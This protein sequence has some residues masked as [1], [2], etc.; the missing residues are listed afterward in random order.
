[1]KNKKT[2]P[3]VFCIALS[4][5]I[6]GLQSCEDDTEICG[7]GTTPRLIIKFYDEAT[8]TEISESGVF[9]TTEFSDYAF[10][11]QDSIFLPLS[12]TNEVDTLFYQTSTDATVTDTIVLTFSRKEEYVS[13]GCGFKVNYYN[14]NAT[15]GTTSET[16]Q[17]IEFNPNVVDADNQ[18]NITDE[19]EAHMFIYF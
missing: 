14:I 15:L 19:T 18:I 10:S 3:I 8:N 6:F 17:K 7:E 13:K 4:I 12:L 9:S 2:L 5:I 11:S 16:L 1:M